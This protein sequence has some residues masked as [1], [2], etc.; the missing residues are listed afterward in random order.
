MGMVGRGVNS[1]SRRLHFPVLV[2]PWLPRS[3][4]L[5]QTTYNGS[6]VPLYFRGYRNV[7]AVLESLVASGFGEAE[8]VIV[9]GD[10]AVCVRECV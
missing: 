6:T 5:V 7:R 1:R 2:I 3:L 4:A 10:S 8:T 9:S